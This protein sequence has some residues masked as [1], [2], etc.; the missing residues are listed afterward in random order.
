VQSGG[1]AIFT[2]SSS[3]TPTTPIIVT[4]TMSGKARLHR[5]YSLSGVPG[6]VTIPAGATSANVTL[7]VLR[8][9]KKMKTATMTL[10]SSSGYSLSASQSASVS[11]QK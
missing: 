9:S 4:Y 11:I 5:T 8:A 7:T 6:Q 2:V 3:V 1:T 10:G